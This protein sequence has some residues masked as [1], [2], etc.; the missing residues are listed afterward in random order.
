M[1]W[2]RFNFLMILGV[3]LQEKLFIKIFF[4]G[5]WLSVRR[6]GT[7]YGWNNFFINV[8]LI[9]IWGLRIL[10]TD[11]NTEAVVQR[12]SVKK[13][14][15]RYFAKF[16][17]KQLCQNLFFNKVAGLRLSI[18]EISMNTLFTEHKVSR[19]TFVKDICELIR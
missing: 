15:L 3:A 12:C 5:N 4:N 7:G 8:Y 1:T 13:G 17:G 9:Y 16:T 14:V 2:K 6:L 19:E 11:I 18:C 10:S